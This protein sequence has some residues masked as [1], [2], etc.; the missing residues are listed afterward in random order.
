MTYIDLTHTFDKEMPAYPGDPCPRLYQI[1]DIPTDG[2]VDH[3]IETGMHVGTHVDAPLHMIAGGKRISEMPLSAFVGRGVLLDARKQSSISHELLEKCDV[4]AGDIV[5]VLTG[6][7]A[8]FKH[9]DYY[10]KFPEITESLAKMLVAK[11]IRAIGMDTAS[12]D[13]APFPIHKIFLNQEIPIIENLCNLEE[14]LH[15]SHFTVTAF[16]AKFL[17]EAAPVRVVAEVMGK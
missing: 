6:F 3:K 4:Q 10:D 16:P 14:L 17:A 7:S 2:Y 5:L 8:L 15:V 9:P 11:G 13:R 12:P 1:A